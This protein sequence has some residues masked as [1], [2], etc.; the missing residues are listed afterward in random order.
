MFRI[1]KAD[2]DSNF[3]REKNDLPVIEA[4]CFMSQK[5][6]NPIQ[7]NLHTVSFLTKCQCLSATCQFT[8][9]VILSNTEPKLGTL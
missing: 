5:V 4:T 8:G 2:C 7:G 1:I 3:T 9:E 6:Q